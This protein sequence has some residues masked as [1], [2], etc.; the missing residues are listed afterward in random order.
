MSRFLTVE[1]VL[2]VHERVIDESGGSHGV[3]DKGLLESA[4]MRP[5]TTFAGEHLYPDLFSQA[6]ALLES[7]TIRSL[8]AIS[9]Q[10]TLPLPFFSL[11]MS[12]SSWHR[13]TNN[14]NSFLK[15]QRGS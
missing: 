2:T 6:S 7:L 11:S 13:P 3:Q 12:L 15:W 14:S 1:E 5:Q 9:G 8:M 4:V 10:D